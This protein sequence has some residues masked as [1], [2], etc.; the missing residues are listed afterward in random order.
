MGK[1]EGLY[2]TITTVLSLGLVCYHFTFYVWRAWN[3]WRDEKLTPLNRRVPQRKWASAAFALI[4]L[5]YL[6]HVM[7]LNGDIPLKLYDLD[8]AYVLVVQLGL[9]AAL[10]KIEQRDRHRK[11]RRL[12][13]EERQR[14]GAHRS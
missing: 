5:G 9:F 1:A 7:H 13:D 2:P 14:Q 4:L 3:H 8:R 11:N 10:Q 12:D 6:P